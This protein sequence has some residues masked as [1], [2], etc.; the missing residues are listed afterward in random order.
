MSAPLGAPLLLLLLLLCPPLLLLLLSLGKTMGSM[1][2][3]LSE[4]PLAM[5]MYSSDEEVKKHK[6]S[7]HKNRQR[8]DEQQQYAPQQQPPQ[9]Q[10]VFAS[11]F[12]PPQQYPPQQ[13]LYIDVSKH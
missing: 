6:E 12:Q 13:Q 2:Y 7:K 10:Y 5:E 11:H 4:T 1:V 8:K 9:Q 3:H